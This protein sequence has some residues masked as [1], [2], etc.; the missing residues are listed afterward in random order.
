MS[1]FFYLLGVRGRNR[2]KACADNYSKRFDHQ[3]ISR[4]QFEG[5]TKWVISEV[6]KWVKNDPFFTENEEAQKTQERE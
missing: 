1:R 2:L 3:Y 4:S 5:F 6:E